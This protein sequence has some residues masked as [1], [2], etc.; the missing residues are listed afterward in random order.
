M[1]P[2]ETAAYAVLDLEPGAPF[3]DVI[4]AWRR[5]VKRHHPDRNPHEDGTRLREVNAAYAHLQQW[6]RRVPPDG[7][8]SVQRLVG[9][10]RAEA[11][12][13][14]FD[15]SRWPNW[16]PGVTSTSAILGMSDRRAT[17]EGHLGAT[18]FMA[19]VVF[20]GVTPNRRLSARI[21]DLRLGGRL[22]DLSVPPRVWMR[23]D[24][25]TA[26]LG[27]KLP[28]DAPWEFYDGLETLLSLALDSLFMPPAFAAAA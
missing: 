9:A 10:R 27:V 26:T 22:I 3:P 20:C 15:T 23:V 28:P 8:V 19:S 4:A 13:R 2:A 11:W 24:G 16:M 6:V 7:V 1:S 12:E 17:I 5:L 14:A 18:R 21:L 25:D